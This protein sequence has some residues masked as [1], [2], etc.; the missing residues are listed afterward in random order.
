MHRLSW[1][2]LVLL[3]GCAGPSA[4][5]TPAAD[6][7]LDL[8]RQRLLLM[9]D[10]ARWKWNEQRPIADPEREQALLAGVERQASQ[11]GVDP[12]LARR[13]FA[14]QIEAAKLVQE[15]DHQRWRNEKQGRFT[16]V[17]DLAKEL[18]PR[19]DD[20]N[21]RLLATLK[22]IGSERHPITQRANVLLAGEGIS[23]AV[24]RA[25]LAPFEEPPR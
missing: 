13:F 23:P 17:P 12:A 10:V 21:S 16:D 8:M 24:R 2:A 18:R 15:E 9:H 1:I 4:P 22:R 3:A 19:I 5:P 7:L 14:A 25:A 6:E 11:L 20:L